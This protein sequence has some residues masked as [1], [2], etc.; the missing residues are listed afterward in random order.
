MA[1]RGAESEAHGELKQLA[2]CWAQ[3]RRL[4]LGACEVRLPRSNYRADAAATTPRLMAE[5]GLTAV[6]ECKVSRADFLRD[7][8]PESATA[9]TV[10]RLGRRLTKLRELIATHRPD[11]RRGEELFPEFDAYDLRGLKHETHDRLTADLRTAQH[12]L[13]DGTKFSRLLRWR[14]ASLLY[15]VVPAG[16]VSHLEVPEGWGLLERHGDELALTLKPC[17]N[18]TTPVERVAL[19]ERIAAAGNRNSSPSLKPDTVSRD[20]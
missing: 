11:L 10:E 4:V 17:L 13:H 12:K 16:L 20:E 8:A 19:L 5:N 15:L 1:R 18:A 7:S 6:F 9:R 3:S 2:L 14:A